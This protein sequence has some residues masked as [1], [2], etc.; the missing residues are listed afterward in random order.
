MIPTYSFAIRIPF[1]SLEGATSCARDTL[2][3]GV[4]IGRC[5]LLDDKMVQVVNKVN[6][7][8]WMEKTTLLYEITG[9]SE[10]SVME[11]IEV[12]KNIAIANGASAE[13]CTVVTEK[14]DCDALWQVRKTCLWSAMTAFPDKEPM[15]TDVAVPLTQL[16]AMMR[17]TRQLLDST[18][19]K[20]PS[21]ILA[22]AGR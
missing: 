8:D 1:P 2:K 22:H 7:M 4:N 17:K 3:C 20:F 16:P 10:T 18:V 14:A 9:L 21:P 5:E 13:L 12:V 11:Q 15:I 19:S 6:S